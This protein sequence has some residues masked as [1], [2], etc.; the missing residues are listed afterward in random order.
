MSNKPDITIIDA[1]TMSFLA[2]KCMTY[3]RENTKCS[4]EK[5]EEMRAMLREEFKI[6]LP[7]ADE[8][9]LLYLEKGVQEQI[10]LYI[11]LIN[12]DDLPDVQRI[13]Y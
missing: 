12:P 10:G 6:I 1:E 4:K 5:L 11:G 9:T 13:G 7:N 2:K 8:L 3:M